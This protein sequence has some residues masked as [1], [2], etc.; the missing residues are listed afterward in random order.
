MKKTTKR[1]FIMLGGVLLLVL[2][3]AG[4]FALHI[5]SLIAA[6]PKPGPQTV[7]TIEA[8][9]LDWQPRLAAVGS[10]TAV[11]GVD[12]TT[13]I[14]GLVRSINFR[15]GQDVAAGAVLIQL[16]ADSDIAQLQSLQAAADLSRR[17]CLATSSSS[18]PTP[19]ARP[20]STTT[21]PT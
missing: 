14:A 7:S 12:V 13:E 16:N 10:V 5:R 11:R 3:L 4:G 21:T 19:S 17:P 1:M 8:Q 18:T 6:A 9:A 15:S 2:V 20:S